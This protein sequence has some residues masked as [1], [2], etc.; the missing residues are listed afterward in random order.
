MFDIVYFVQTVVIGLTAIT[1]LVLFA[2]LLRAPAVGHDY[3]RRWVTFTK[4]ALGTWGISRIL[5]TISSIIF[6]AQNHNND[7]YYYAPGY[8]RAYN[9]LYLICM[10]IETIGHLF[11]YLALFFLAH[12]LTQLRTGT[13]EESRAYLRGRAFSF[14]AVSLVAVLAVVT[15][16]LYMSSFVDM[17][18]GYS[19]YS[20]SQA[21]V[22]M[23]KYTIAMALKVAIPGI[24]IICGLGVMIYAIKSR[25]KARGTPVFKAGT[26]L[27]VGSIMFILRNAW[28]LTMSIIQFDIF[29]ILDIV[30]NH[31]A[32]LVVLVLLYVLATQDKFNLSEAQY[33][34]NVGTKEET[35]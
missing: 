35:V 11:I 28:D 5:Y 34:A 33:R 1:T 8:F 26:L 6:L 20:S 29:G 19:Y 4:A 30:L 27:L 31:W 18:R 12:A 2:L 7:L 32:T 22:Y 16:G 21:D 17:M 13:N 14:S 10:T 24:L 9:F 23:I 3:T 25:S 15:M